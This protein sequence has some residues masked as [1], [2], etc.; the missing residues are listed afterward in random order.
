MN[1]TVNYTLELRNIRKNNPNANMYFE[2]TRLTTI[3]N[4]EVD[5]EGYLAYAYQRLNSLLSNKH[6]KQCESMTDKIK[7]Q[8]QYIRFLNNDFV[9]TGK[10]VMREDLE[11]ALIANNVK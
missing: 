10:A 1:T 4:Q 5:T 3:C 8:I 9:Y 7:G 6:N 2:H 11:K